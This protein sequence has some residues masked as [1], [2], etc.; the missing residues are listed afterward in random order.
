MSAPEFEDP[1]VTV[2]RLI[3][4]RIRVVR[5]DD[6]LASNLCSQEH[7]D[8]E[9]LKNY[10]ATVTVGQA[11]PCIEQKHTVDGKLRRRI[12]ALK[13]TVTTF[14]KSASGSDTGKV[15]RKKTVEQILAIVRENRNQP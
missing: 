7:P 15:M 3:E 6:S 9:L 11:S 8:R 13:A 5:D 1:I 12:Y 14:D 2:L 4:S 10:D